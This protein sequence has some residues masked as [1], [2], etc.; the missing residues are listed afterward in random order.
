[1]DRVSD[2]GPD[3]R[4]FN[5]RHAYIYENIWKKYECISIYCGI[6]KFRNIGGCNGID[7]LEAAIMWYKPRLGTSCKKYLHNKCKQYSKIL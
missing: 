4:G 6:N 2:S 7:A 1:M 3:G 5:S